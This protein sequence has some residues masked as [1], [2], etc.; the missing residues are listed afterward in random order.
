MPTCW[1]LLPSVYPLYLRYIGGQT[2]RVKVPTCWHL[3]PSVYPLYL[4]YIG[5]QTIEV[6]CEWSICWY[7]LPCVSECSSG[8]QVGGQSI[9]I[10]CFRFMATLFC[11]CSR[12]ISSTKVYFSFFLSR[13]TE[14][15]SGD[16][17]YKPNFVV[18][19]LSLNDG[20]ILMHNLRCA[21]C[22]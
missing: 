1:H 21:E 18:T 20:K 5:G 3:L 8:T 10:I 9:V 14:G 11:C 7:L 13:L 6:A 16:Q 15:S 19:E 22:V 12:R 2:I 17:C 4:R